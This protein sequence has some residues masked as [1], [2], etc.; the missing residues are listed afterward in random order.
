M[1]HSSQEQ[2]NKASVRESG[3]THQMPIDYMSN[4]LKVSINGEKESKNV[5]KQWEKPDPKIV[6]LGAS[7]LLKYDKDQNNRVNYV[8]KTAY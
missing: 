8:I 7:A 4:S 3:S 6:K 2:P 5:S 1:P